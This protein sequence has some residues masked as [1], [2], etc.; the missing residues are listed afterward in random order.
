MSCLLTLRCS[1]QLSVPEASWHDQ[2]PHHWPH[3]PPEQGA[4]LRLL[5]GVV[6]GLWQ[7]WICAQS[8]QNKTTTQQCR[9]I[10]HCVSLLGNIPGRLWQLGKTRLMTA[11]G[12]STAAVRAAEQGSSWAASGARA[13]EVCEVWSGSLSCVHWNSPSTSHRS[14]SVSKGRRANSSLCNYLPK[15]IPLQFQSAALD[16]PSSGCNPSS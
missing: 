16:I 14:S 12:M 13:Q 6:P 3:L 2:C 9:A 7:H 10:S 11:Q 5:L 15:L 8:P 1:S 4:P